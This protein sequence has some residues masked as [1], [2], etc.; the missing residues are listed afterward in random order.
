MAVQTRTDKRFHRAHV[1]P[2]RRRRAAATRRRVA[3]AILLGGLTSM[4]AFLVPS[5]LRTAPFLRVSTITVHGNDYVSKG[6]VLALI[7]QLQGENILVADLEAYRDQLLTSGWIKSATLRR[8]LPTTVE[9]GV[10]ERVPVAFGRFGTRL[11]LVDEVGAVIDEHGPR[12]ADLDLP[13]V[14]GLAS[15]MGG[16]TDAGRAR[17]AASVLADLKD[18][19]SI[20]SRVSQ[21]DVRD[22]YDAVIM[23]NDDPTLVHLGT[24]R[25]VD[26]IREYLELT[27]A[28][29]AHVPNIDYVDMRFDKRIFVGPAEPGGQS[30]SLVASSRGARTISI[31]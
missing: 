3:G 26:R 8:V 4:A 5:A 23:L 1:K 7:G 6:E 11:Y 20:A 13:I 22:P 28:L 17:L 27:P 14:D 24:E 12:F 21:I 15:S 30:S 31:Q 2:S 16:S 10:E 18:A 25:F 19:P 29:R 9:V